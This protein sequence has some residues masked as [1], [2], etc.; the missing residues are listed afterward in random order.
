[1]S[2]S[3]EALSF[4]YGDAEILKDVSFSVESGNVLCILGPNGVG[5]STLFN[6]ILGLRKPRCGDIIVEGTNIRGISI[7]ER[8]K[9]MAYI[10]QSHAPSFNYSVYDMVLMGTAS[11]VGF[12]SSPGA[13]QKSS[14]EK[15]LKHLNLWELRNRSYMRISGG[16]R[17]L[18]C[19]A[20]ALVQGAKVL[21]MDE[22]T[23]NLDYGNQIMVQEQLRKLAADNYTILQSTHNPEQAFLFADFVLT[24][25]E[26]RVASMGKPEDAICKASM[27]K[28]Y[29]ADVEIESLH[30]DLVRVCIP[31]VVLEEKKR[32]G[33]NEP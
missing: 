24:L 23:A 5:K 8:A 18:V 25:S 22:P 30:D 13:R 32:R 27:R 31:S 15:V 6:C 19:I 29:N 11:C 12:G 9:L 14:V 28:L 17:Q 10:P 2:I 1:M 7:K 16:E 21:I 4:S 26:G 20:R 3:V 33:R